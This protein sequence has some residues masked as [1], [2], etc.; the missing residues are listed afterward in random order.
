MRQ[1][2]AMAWALGVGIGHWE[3]GVGIEQRRNES[4][5]IRGSFSP[6]SSFG[7]KSDVFSRV[8][9]PPIPE[10]RPH[11]LV[12]CVGLPE[13]GGREGGFRGCTDSTGHSSFVGHVGLVGY[14]HS[15]WGVHTLRGIRALWAMWD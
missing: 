4:N 9:K 12:G 6:E 10:S 13:G 7:E 14:F 3:L 2:T 11:T 15:S 5:V 1:Y 8:R